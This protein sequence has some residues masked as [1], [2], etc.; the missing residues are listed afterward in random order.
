MTANEKTRFWYRLLYR[1]FVGMV[2]ISIGIYLYYLPIA[3]IKDDI[4]KG[5]FQGVQFGLTLPVFF[6]V[7]GLGILMGIFDWCLNFAL[8]FKTA[9]KK[10]KKGP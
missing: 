9:F 8:S 4:L 7:L 5:T 10:A 2:S 1:V 3:N 6:L